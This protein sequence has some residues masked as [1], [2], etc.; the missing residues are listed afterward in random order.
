[1]RAARKRPTAAAYDPEC[2]C[3][4]MLEVLDSPDADQID[5]IAAKRLLERLDRMGLLSPE[6]SAMLPWKNRVEV[7]ADE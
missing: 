3:A 5:R 7:T 1:M 6:T 2:V 4:Y